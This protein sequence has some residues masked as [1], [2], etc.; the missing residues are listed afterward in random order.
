MSMLTRF[1]NWLRPLRLDRD[2]DDEIDFHLQMRTDQH[3]TAGMSAGEAT[4]R[5]KQEFGDIEG[6][7]RQ[8]RHARLT[9]VTTLVA[10][11][12]VLVMAFFWLALRPMGRADLHLPALPAAPIV[13]EED[14]PADS[15]PPP[16]PPPP[17]W[18]EFVAKVNTFGG[19]ANDKANIR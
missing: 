2:L 13:W 9:S 19:A 6:I 4:D 10:I 11:T 18:E 5:A 7:R 15:P 16:P 17:T 8:M 14:R 3:V 12:S 1:T